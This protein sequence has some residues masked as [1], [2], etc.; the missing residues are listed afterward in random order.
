[1]MS[2]KQKTIIIVSLVIVFLICSTI[3]VYPF[4]PFIKYY[5]NPPDTENTENFVNVKTLPSIDDQEETIEAKKE[6]ITE[7]K[8]SASKE[9]IGNLLVISKIGVRIQIVEGEDESALNRGAWRMP[10]TSTPDQGSNTVITG[11]RWKYRPPSE[12]TF[13]LLNKLE[14]GDIFQVF[15]ED[16][17][18]RYKVVSSE[19]V[20]P[21]ALEVLDPTEISIVTLLTC[22]PLFSTKQRL[23]VKGELIMD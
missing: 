4:L 3:I 15:W 23:I 11:H 22:H 1:M 17:E 5:I 2:R 18:Y 12:K 6:E 9:I 13:Y 20:A 19:I 7:E 10:E 16:K 14:Q 21:T 8:S